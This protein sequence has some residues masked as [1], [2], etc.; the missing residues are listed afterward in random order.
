MTGQSLGA[1]QKQI[2]DLGDRMEKG[3]AEIKEMIKGFD[4]RMRNVEQNQ[5]GCQ[6]ILTAR[7]EAA[8]QKLAQLDIKINELDQTLISQRAKITELQHTNNILK[9]LLGIATTLVIGIAL[10]AANRSIFGN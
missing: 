9:W 2:D 5:A 10:A 8:F 4:V 7:I 6:P 1:L 3:F